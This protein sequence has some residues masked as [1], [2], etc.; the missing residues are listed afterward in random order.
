V[1]L[2]RL[3]AAA[4]CLALLL[5]VKAGAI[6][7]WEELTFPNRSANDW[8]VEGETVRVASRSSVSVLY[9]QVDLPAAAAE[10]VTWRWCAQ[11]ALPATDLTR[12]GGD[13]RAIALYLGFSDPE[14]EV[15][16]SLI[17]RVRERFTGTTPDRVLIYIW[18]GAAPT[19]WLP[20][21]HLGERGAIRVVRTA[22]EVGRCFEELVDAVE[23]FRAVW[24]REPGRLTQLALSAD[25]DDTVSYTH[26]TLPT[27]A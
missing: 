17:E 1:P 5:P 2:P 24:G 8:S 14:G 20:S 3:L 15:R 4:A 13:D 10:Q 7:P 11:G 16:R 6:A 9:R 27:K 22:A 26:L 18:G 21:P 19:G 12:R 23:D 25:T